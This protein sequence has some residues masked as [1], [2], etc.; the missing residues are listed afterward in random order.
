MS[1]EEEEEDINDDELELK[2]KKEKNVY[3]HLRKV[4]KLNH[5]IDKIKDIKQKV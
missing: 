4:D 3:K 5:F 1:S 2:S